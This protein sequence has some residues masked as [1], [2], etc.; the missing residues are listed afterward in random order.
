MGQS[1]NIGAGTITCNYDG[2]NKHDTLIGDQ[3]FIGCN[4][5][6]IAPVV[7]G[8]KATIGA[9]SVIT[10]D[11]DENTLTLSRAKQVSV[12]GWIRKKDKSQ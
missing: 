12:P 10:H 6:M 8:Q 9:G 11:A 2:L 7:I 5:A 1:V 3:A 4:T